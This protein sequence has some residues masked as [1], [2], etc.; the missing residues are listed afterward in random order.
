[1]EARQIWLRH[2]PNPRLMARILDTR[3]PLYEIAPL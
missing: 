2:A 3:E 1:M